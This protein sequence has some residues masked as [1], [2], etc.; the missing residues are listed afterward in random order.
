MPQGSL[1]ATLCSE[2]RQLGTPCRSVA[3]CQPVFGPT[4]GNQERAVEFALEAVPKC[5]SR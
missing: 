3:G 5:S 2:N 4:Q 1:S